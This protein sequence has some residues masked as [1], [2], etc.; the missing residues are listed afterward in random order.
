MLRIIVITLTFAALWSVRWF[1][2]AGTNQAMIENWLNDADSV[3]YS[4]IRQVGF[5]NR[6]DVTLNDFRISNA[7]KEL[8]SSD[9]MQ[10]MRL[11]YRQDHFVMA[12]SDQIKI[13]G[14][15]IKSSSNRVSLVKQENG[16]HRIVWEA[17]DIALGSNA[18]ITHGQLAILIP[19]A[20]REIMMYLQLDEIAKDGIVLHETSKLKAK[21]NL[22]TAIETSSLANF[23]NSLETS[24]VSADL[25]N[26][27]NIDQMVKLIDTTNVVSAMNHFP[28][29]A[30]ILN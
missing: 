21:I 3:N 20:G 30:A 8:F 7:E 14:H 9:V 15:D 5:P 12:F 25:S 13:F 22:R 19:P 16:F 24:F 18:T 23:I 2:F 29:I 17:R 10:I 1:W 4:D 26:P 27:D 28:V 11:A 6:Y